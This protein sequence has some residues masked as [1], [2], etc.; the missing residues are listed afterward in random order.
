[1]VDI[2]ALHATVTRLAENV[3]RLT[4]E[5]SGLMSTHDEG[6]YGEDYAADGGPAVRVRFFERSSDHHS[7]RIDE[8]KEQV[9]QR[10]HD[11]RNYIH[12]DPQQ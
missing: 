12:P 8:H 6:V 4:L 1:M 7:G 3:G 9:T 11:G 2:E 5:V 10:G